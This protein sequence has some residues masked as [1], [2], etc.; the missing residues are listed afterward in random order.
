ML[1]VRKTDLNRLD[2]IFEFFV[3]SNHSLLVTMNSLVYVSRK[4]KRAVTRLQNMRFRRGRK[5]IPAAS[6]NQKSLSIGT[7]EKR[8]VRVDGE[9]LNRL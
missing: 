2:S 4:K 7:I 1:S 5:K 9:R 6:E 8:R 3:W